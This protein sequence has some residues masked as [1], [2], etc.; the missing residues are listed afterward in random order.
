LGQFLLDRMHPKHFQP[1][2]WSLRLV[3]LLVALALYH[4]LAEGL[5]FEEGL[6]VQYVV[7]GITAVSLIAFARQNWFAL[8]QRVV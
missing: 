5:D 3:A 8:K 2:A 7:A 6:P 4:L 1:T